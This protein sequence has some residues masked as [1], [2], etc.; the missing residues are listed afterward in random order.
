MSDPNWLDGHYYGKTFP[1][2]GMQNA[3]YTMAVCG[4]AVRVN[5]RKKHHIQDA[6]VLLTSPQ[7]HWDCDLPECDGVAETVSRETEP[8]PVSQLLCRL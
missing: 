2:V 6:D 5:V 8:R 4:C 3:R 1:K 7:G